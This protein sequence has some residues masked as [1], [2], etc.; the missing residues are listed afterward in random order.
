MMREGQSN[1]LGRKQP[2]RAHRKVVIMSETVSFKKYYADMRKADDKF[3]QERDRRYTEVKNAEEKAL[4]IKE[5]A[6][7]V[8]RELAS[9]NQ[10]DKDEQHNGL[11]KQH[12]DFVAKAATQN[13]L[14]ALEDKFAT[15]LKPVSDYMT[16]TQGQKQG[17]DVT[18]GKI[19]AIVGISITVLG[20][21][22][23]I[24]VMAAN[25]RLG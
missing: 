8:A 9:Q 13:D 17:S 22:L 16:S 14:K 21:V 25:G 18:I 6:D 11:L 12:A 23:G 2:Q 1:G 24:V 20:F 5:D 15:A 4:K 10:K 3:Q 7:K 19:I